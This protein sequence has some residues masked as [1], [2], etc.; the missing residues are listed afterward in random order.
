[1]RQRR[2]HGLRELRRQSQRRLVEEEDARPGNQRAPDGHHLLLA[3][4]QGPAIPLA[5][6]LQ[7][8]EQVVDVVDG[9]A[10]ASPCARQRSQLEVLVHVE[11]REHVPALGNVDQPRACEVLEVQLP[12]VDTVEHHGAVVR[13]QPGDGTEGRRLPGAV[14][15]D[16]RDDLAHLH[17]EVDAA[18]C[19]HRAVRHLERP[20]LEHQS[21]SATPR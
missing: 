5:E 18:H 17:V 11:R 4:G 2:V 13:Y 14:R 7:R 1:L 8:R 3:T 9:K 12:A 15:A 10:L 6:G 20:D 19:P 21:T 16:Q